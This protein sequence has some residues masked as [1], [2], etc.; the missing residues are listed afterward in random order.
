MNRNG[1][2]SCKRQDREALCSRD[3]PLSRIVVLVVV[4]VVFFPVV[5]HA[6]VCAF[7]CLVV[8]CEMKQRDRE[9]ERPSR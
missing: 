4:L 6:C 8:L 5:V 1:K 9:R 3:Q 2:C 7:R